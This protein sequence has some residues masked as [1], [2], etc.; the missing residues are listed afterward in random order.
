MDVCYLCGLPIGDGTGDVDH[1]PAKQFFASELRKAVN[2]Q[3]VTRPTHKKCNWS[4]KSDEE[5]FAASM[6]PFAADTLAGRAVVQDT[7]RRNS[8]GRALGLT[9]RVLGE[10]D[11]RPSGLYIP[12]KYVVKRI[13]RPRVDRVTWKIIRGLYFVEH[14]AVLPEETPLAIEIIGPNDDVPDRYNAVLASPSRGAYAAV[15][16]YKNHVSLHGDVAV[17]VWALLFWDKLMIF[18]LYVVDKDRL[19]ERVPV[20]KEMVL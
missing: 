11:R 2:L 15:F 8:E 18:A 7:V 3:L 12:D 17:D 13:D 4:F 19:P 14:G 5:Y 6:I 1:V 16:D 20:M 10:L 9:K